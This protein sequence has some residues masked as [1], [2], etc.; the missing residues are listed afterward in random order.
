MDLLVHEDWELFLSYNTGVRAYATTYAIDVSVFQQTIWDD[1]KRVYEIQKLAIN[2][3]KLNEQ[4]KNFPAPGQNQF[5]HP[6][7]IPHLL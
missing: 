4:D 5:P 7:L 1:C 2:I 6:A 3:K